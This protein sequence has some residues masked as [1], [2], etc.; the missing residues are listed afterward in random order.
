MSLIIKRPVILKNIVTEEFKKR[1][2]EDLSNT[3]K[4]IDIKIDQMNFQER[5][6]IANDKQQGKEEIG[7]MRERLRQE[8]ARQKRIRDDLQRKLNEIPSLEIGSEFIS[9]TYDAPVKIEVGDNIMKKLSQ[10][11]IIIKNGIVVEI[12]D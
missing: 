2:M 10:A 11:E 9:G 1:L 4:Q 5:R 3:I 6:V 12:R 7:V 8:K